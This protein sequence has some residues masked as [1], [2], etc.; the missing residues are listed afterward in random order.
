M[1]PHT[2][3]RNLVNPIMTPSPADR[4]TRHLNIHRTVIAGAD[5]LADRCR[6]GDEGTELADR[7]TEQKAV[8][9]TAG[10]RDDQISGQSSPSPAVELDG[11]DTATDDRHVVWNAFG[12]QGAPA[13][14]PTGRSSADSDRHQS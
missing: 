3:P 4:L 8:T 11:L 10:E 5:P 13:A 9:A 6:G 2:S 12:T 7:V 1:M 14:I